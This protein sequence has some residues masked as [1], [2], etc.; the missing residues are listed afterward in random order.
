MNTTN[1]I[2]KTAIDR[3]QLL[4]RCLG[5]DAFAQKIATAFVATLPNE[6]MALRSALSSA[7][8]TQVA[9]HAHRLRGSASNVCANELSIA[10]E[11]VEQAARNS[12]TESTLSL[13]ENVEAAIDRILQ[14]FDNGIAEL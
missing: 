12:H 4:E 11:A 3:S 5:I 9:R 6:R 13:I 1:S 14:E 7:D 10:A 2:P 8:W